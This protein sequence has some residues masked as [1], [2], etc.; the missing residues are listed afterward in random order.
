MSARSREATGGR[1]FG[2]R[3]RQ[4]VIVMLAMLS[5]VLTIVKI[6]AIDTNIGVADAIMPLVFTWL[7]WRFLL[8]GARLP[9]AW[10]CCA[11][12]GVI[13]L[14]L[15]ANARLALGARGPMG[16]VVEPL[17]VLLLWGYFYAVVNLARS[18]GDVLLLVRSWLV[19]SALVGMAGIYGSLSYHLWGARTPFAL[20]N[21]A[22]G[23][24][25]DPNFFS[26]HMAVSLLLAMFYCQVSGRRPK[27]IAP[28]AVLQLV[29]I[30]LS[31]S[32]SGLLALGVSLT[33]LL[34]LWTGIR[35]KLVL[36]ASAV[37]LAGI[38]LLLPNS[39]GWLKSNPF[40]ARLATTTLDPTQTDRGK[41]WANAAQAFLSSPVLGVGYGNA[42]HFDVRREGK[43]VEAHNTYLGLLAETGIAGLGVYL[44]TILYFPV[45]L[46][47]DA[48]RAASPKARRPSQ[49]L[50]A[51]FVVILVAGIPVNVENFRGLW[52]LMGVAFCFRLH[53]G[54]FGAGRPAPAGAAQRTWHSAGISAARAG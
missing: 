37:V 35:T 14:S 7:A 9:L 20:D 12:I 49:A 41:L 34:V 54:F 46:A 40:T 5:P 38:L 8:R 22:H 26:M 39:T 6:G 30:V 13:A 15:L 33:L 47:R 43:M 23:T 36:A 19:G 10:A 17:K 52:I 29:A 3:F 2:G 28:L 32:R 42:A 51:A 11:T 31:A 1:D 50:L 4:I 21:R 44:A 27:W 53:W 24:M 48:L 45:V 18:R 16:L 25:G